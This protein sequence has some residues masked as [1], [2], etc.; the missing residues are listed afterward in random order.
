M[1]TP[2]TPSDAKKTEMPTLREEHLTQFWARYGSSIYFVCGAIAFAILAKGGWEYLNAQKELG[3][4]REYAQCVTTDSFRSFAANHPGHPLTGAAEITIADNAYNAGKYAE[5]LGA[6]TSAIA[7]LPAGP[8]QARARMGQAMSQAL[9]GKAADAEANL[10]KLMNDAGLLKTTRC[11]A[12]YHLAVLALDSG[13]GAEVQGL[14]EQ[15][16]RIDP[17]SPFAERAFSLRP[18]APEPLAVPAAHAL[19]VP[20]KP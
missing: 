13:R 17:T 14:A 2:A 10:R 8:I 7:D 9:T 5:A 1:T 16:L 11:E 4:Q 18:A 12:G 15:L 6:Y 3:I 20:A 19:A